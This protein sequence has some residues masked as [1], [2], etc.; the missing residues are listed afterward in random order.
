MDILNISLLRSLVNQ[1]YLN[2]QYLHHL[3]A[4]SL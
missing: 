2:G 1:V 4:V 3:P